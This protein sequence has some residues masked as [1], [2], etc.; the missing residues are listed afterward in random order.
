VATLVEESIT[1][2]DSD[3]VDLR[4]GFTGSSRH[5]TDYQVEAIRRYFRYLVEAGK[6]VE[7]HHGDCVEADEI[8]HGLAFQIGFRIVIHPPNITNRRAFCR[9]YAE[10]REEKP[11]LSRNT[12]IVNETDRL[13]AVPDRP[14]TIRSGTWFT[15]RCAERQRKPVKL[16]LP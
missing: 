8:A 2:L 10:I 5:V 7:F 9:D 12:D 16:I 3:A 6:R 11:Y 14:R 13:L 1:G 4:L 15:V